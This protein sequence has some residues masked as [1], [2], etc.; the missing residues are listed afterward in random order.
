MNKQAL[1][2][3]LDEFLHGYAGEVA[4]LKFISV[5]QVDEAEIDEIIRRYG[6]DSGIAKAMAWHIGAPHIDQWLQS[7][8]DALLGYCPIDVITQ[9]RDGEQCIK[10]LLMQMP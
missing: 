4:W 5:L 7:Q 1:P 2:G 9:Y 6:F 3:D 10:M 8:V